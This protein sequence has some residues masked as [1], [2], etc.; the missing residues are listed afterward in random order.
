MD[1]WSEPMS[2]K[3]LLHLLYM[4]LKQCFFFHSLFS[5][6]SSPKMVILQYMYVYN[7]KK[8]ALKPF[9]DIF[10]TFFFKFYFLQHNFYM[11]EYR[12]YFINIFPKATEKQWKSFEICS[13]IGHQF[14]YWKLAYIWI[15]E[16]RIK[17]LKKSWGKNDTKVKSSL[18]LFNFSG[19]F[20][21]SLC[22]KN[23]LS[24]PFV[25]CWFLFAFL[26]VYHIFLK[27]FFHPFL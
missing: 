3:Q 27:T 15:A 10:W 18:W 21:V 19:I 24:D 7:N 4:H 12:F 13:W 2:R 17:H 16:N 6:K 25:F 1:P 14:G 26:N 8:D 9:E 22:F 11:F 5:V 20:L 23:I